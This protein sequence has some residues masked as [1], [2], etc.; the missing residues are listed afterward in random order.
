MELRSVSGGEKAAVFLLLASV[1]LAV[2]VWVQMAFFFFGSAEEEAWAPIAGFF[3]GLVFG[4]F[5]AVIPA[6][7]AGATLAS[8]ETKQP[9]AKLVLVVSLLWIGLVLWLYLV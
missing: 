8:A 7:V 4:G 1:A 6:V 2:G 5:S 9:W 3:K